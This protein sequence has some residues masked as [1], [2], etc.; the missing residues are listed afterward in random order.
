MTTVT[1]RKHNAIVDLYSDFNLDD[2][3]KIPI[4]HAQ[5]VWAKIGGPQTPQW[6]LSKPGASAKSKKSKLPEFMLYLLPHMLAGGINICPWSC[7][8]CRKHCLVTSGR[9]AQP[10]V[11][12]GRYART[13]L[14]LEH[15][16][17][18]LRLL[19]HDLERT[20][21]KYGPNGAWVRMNGTSDIPWERIFDGVWMNRD[22]MF[23][24]YTKA[25]VRERP[26]PEFDN[27]V[28]SRSVWPE[29]DDVVDIANLLNMGERVV[30]VVDYPDA[31]RHP[32]VAQ[33]D[34][35]DEWLF[36][37]GTKL[38]LLSPKGTL[39]YDP[40]NYYQS[41]IAVAALSMQTNMQTN[42]QVVV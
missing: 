25:N 37:S 34:K 32:L 16:D 5:N 27:Y 13:L 22:L 4:K 17:V 41:H 19:R 28:L 24:D 15:P 26:Q 35:T 23:A 31:V 8:G 29:R 33:A 2:I 10:N 39:R 21:T 36:K 14:L 20:V 3:A 12:Q 40:T 7:K 18:F 11:N 1:I 9:G 30:M 38:G 6:L 42:M